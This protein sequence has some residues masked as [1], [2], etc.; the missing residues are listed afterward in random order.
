MVLA[1]SLTRLAVSLL[2]IAQT[3]MEL[4]AT[5]VEEQSLRYFSCLLLALA[6]LFCTGI[7]VVLGVLLALVL[8]WDTHRIGILLTLIVLFAIA[9]I[10][11]GMRLRRQF[12]LKPKLLNQTVTELS[13][14]G[15]ML[16]PPA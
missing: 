14:D 7:A 10:A 16:R 13:R 9:G 11:T 8:F 15:E 12:Q 6:A 4:A 2:A 5:E 3:R 1:D